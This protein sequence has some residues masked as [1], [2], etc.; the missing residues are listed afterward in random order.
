[1]AANIRRMG[2][3]PMLGADNSLLNTLQWEENKWTYMAAAGGALLI[4]LALMR[5]KKRRRKKKS[6]T[7][8]G[9]SPARRPGS[10]SVSYQG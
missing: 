3:V 8:T 7:P 2:Y 10:L 5:R 9:A 6:S 4:G 1:M